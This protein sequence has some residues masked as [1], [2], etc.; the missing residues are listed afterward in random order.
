MNERLQKELLRAGLV[1]KDQLA[2]AK[3]SP[4]G[5]RGR[6]LAAL[7]D[8]PGIDAEKL[9]RFLARHYKV[10][11]LD[12][13]RVQKPDEK[14][15]KA[16]GEKLCLDNDFLPIDAVSDKEWVIATTDPHN[17]GRLDAIS[18]KLGRRLKTV[19]ARPDQIQRKIRE[20]FQGDAAF[21]AAMETLEKDGISDE[22]L[23]VEK[24]EKQV[25]DL[26]A[27]KRG[28]EESPIIKLVNGIIIK[29]MKIGSSDIHIEPGEGNTVVRLRVDGRLRPV[30]HF[31]H[32][33]HPLVVSRIKIMGALDI[34]NTRTPQDGRT[35]VKMWGKHYDLRVS[36][37]PAMHGEKVVMRILDKSA[38]SLELDKLGFEPLADK[39][40]RRAIAMPTGAVL[41]TGPTGSGKTTT[42]YAAIGIRRRED[43]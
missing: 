20:W 33:A 42:L 5:K 3:A 18:F 8:Q 1:T 26:D 6:L 29:A 41:V 19:F 17:F 43:T 40:V 12:L 30:L 10:P 36:T 9:F 38:L 13:D 15:L 24:G 22:E 16:C 7:L 32:S 21:D 37:L 31:P 23:D 2:D 27:L 14:I 11:F 25:A 35:R 4:A 39:R 28:A 34:S